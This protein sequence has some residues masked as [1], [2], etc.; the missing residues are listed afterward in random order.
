MRA[1]GNLDRYS[2]FVLEGPVR[3]SVSCE[4]CT[5]SRWDENI[6]PDVKHAAVDLLGGLPGLGPGLVE[7]AESQAKLSKL[8]SE[9][10]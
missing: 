5:E 4:D 2:N 3:R 6:K 8:E 7:D 10:M 1:R 9:M